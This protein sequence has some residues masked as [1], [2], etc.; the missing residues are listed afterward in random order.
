M[1]TTA[2][3]VTVFDSR[4]L[5]LGT[6]FQVL[7]AAQA[8]E[9]GQPMSEIRSMLEG[10]IL[11]IAALDTHEFLHRSGRMN[12]A[13]SFLGTL[14]QIKPLMKMYSGNPTAERIRTRHAAVKRL[15]ELLKES[16]P[17]EKVALLHS[18]AT[19]LLEQVRHLLPTGKILIE[20]INPVL[21]A[22][23]SRGVLGFACVSKK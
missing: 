15:I 17:Y 4:Q 1:E 12:F 22:H 5:S 11:R 9:A 2:V 10:L 20:E 13:F 19:A 7:A 23:I 14:L 16:Q 6:G 21:G 3:P 18:Q 8:A